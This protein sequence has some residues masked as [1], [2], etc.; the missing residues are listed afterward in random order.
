MNWKPQISVFMPTLVA[1]L[2]DKSLK[3]LSYQ[4]ISGN[5]HKNTKCAN[6]L[7]KQLSVSGTATLRAAKQVYNQHKGHSVDCRAQS[8]MKFLYWG[9]QMFKKLHF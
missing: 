5:D 4:N 2:D 8:K 7:R 3:P 6:S 1:F 9:C